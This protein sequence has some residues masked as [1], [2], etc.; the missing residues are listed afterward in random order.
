MSTRA[1][2]LFDF[3]GT[4]ARGDSLLGYL[5]GYLREHPARLLR[6][7]LVTPQLLRS[8]I[9]GID[10]GG[11][12]SA[13]IRMVLGGRTRAE[14]ADWTTRFVP[15]LI[16]TGLNADALTVIAAHLDAGDHTVLLSASP[17]LY[18]P[19]VARTL[20]FAETICTG[21]QWR[22]DR[23]TGALATPNRRG[24]EKVRCV[25]ALRG[26]YPELPI[27]AYA[28]AV[29]D[30]AHLALA[31]RGTLVNGSAQAKRAAVRLGLPSVT[32]R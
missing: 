26:R 10:R 21:L 30:L 24:V 18:V 4:I 27:V 3:D 25:E 11:L 13:W 23:L 31:D 20:G 9:A 6:L 29:S 16:G 22:G 12:K 7:P 5:I 19:S 1:L 15:H 14:L 32:W 2:A 28:N 8:S 17:D